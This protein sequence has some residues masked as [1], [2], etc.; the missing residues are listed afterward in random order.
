MQ[1]P[2]A[3]ALELTRCVTELGF[4]GAMVNCF[5]Q[6]HVQVRRFITICG[7]WP[8]WATV[9]ELDIPLYLHPR[10]TIPSRGNVL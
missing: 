9:A 1:D 4:K 10:L 6:R 2:E 8:F 3:A 5:T 7:V